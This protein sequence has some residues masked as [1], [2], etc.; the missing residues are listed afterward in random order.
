[1]NLVVQVFLVLLIF[2]NRSSY[3]LGSG[4]N[5]EINPVDVP[6]KWVCLGHSLSHT[7]CSIKSTIF[8]TSFC[9]SIMQLPSSLVILNCCPWV[10]LGYLWYDVLG[11]KCTSTII[12]WPWRCPV[13][14]RNIKS[15]NI[16]FSNGRL[17]ENKG[18][19]HV[20]ENES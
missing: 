16:C 8:L 7:I 1:M 13:F 19:H 15:L 10:L 6:F 9:L 12:F 20:L 14:S 2:L 5:L 17:Q 3:S 18:L 11:F 4:T